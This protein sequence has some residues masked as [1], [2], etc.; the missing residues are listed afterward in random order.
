[1]HTNIPYLN[2]INIQYDGGWYT[3]CTLSFVHNK[4][5]S[6]M[7]GTATMTMTATLLLLMA[8]A[9]LGADGIATANMPVPTGLRADGTNLL[10]KNLP[11]YALDNLTPKLEW[12]PAADLSLRSPVCLQTLGVFCSSLYIYLHLLNTIILAVISICLFF[13][14]TYFLM[15]F[16]GLSFLFSSLNN[17]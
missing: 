11:I 10:D 14:W 9:M 12:T 3:F 1:M 7:T 6:L 4:T 15:T 5:K 2:C 8:S 17:L 16:N 13:P